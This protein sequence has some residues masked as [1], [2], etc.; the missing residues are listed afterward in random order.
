[1]I[2]ETQATEDSDRFPGRGRTLGSGLSQAAPTPNPDSTLQTRLLDDR[3]SLD[4]PSHPARLQ[5]SDG[6]YYKVHYAC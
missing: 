1:M 2:Y 5:L 3:N 6:R 4:H